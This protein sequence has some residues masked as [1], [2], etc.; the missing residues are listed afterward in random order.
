MTVIS[1]LAPDGTRAQT[2]GVRIMLYLF[3]APIALFYA[4]LLC[5]M[6]HRAIAKSI[7]KRRAY[8]KHGVASLV[9]AAQRR[10]TERYSSPA[11]YR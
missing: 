9:K 2:T 4:V 10:A 3:L 7:A 8:R 5:I 6:S 11:L 1:R